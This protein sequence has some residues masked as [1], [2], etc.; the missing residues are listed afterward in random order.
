[1]DG[2]RGQQAKKF[3][4]PKY[5]ANPFGVGEFNRT[6]FQEAL[7]DYATVACYRLAKCTRVE[8]FQCGKL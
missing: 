8:I 3:R 4:Q 2:I 7:Q 6:K 5:G 1:V